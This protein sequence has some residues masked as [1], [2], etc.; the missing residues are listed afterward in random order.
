MKNSLT[1]AAVAAFGLMYVVFVAAGIVRERRRQRENSERRAQEYLQALRS[2]TGGEKPSQL[3]APCASGMSDIDFPVQDAVAITRNIK[4]VLWW[5][6]RREQR[7]QR[8]RE[9]LEAVR[10]MQRPPD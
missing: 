2:E 4:S 1:L 6:K 9:Y 3:Q 8:E 7:E 5:R 10:R